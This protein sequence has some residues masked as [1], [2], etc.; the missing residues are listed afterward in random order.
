MMRVHSQE[1]GSHPQRDSTTQR[2]GW[3]EGE[4][5]VTKLH[6]EKGLDEL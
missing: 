5:E 2:W 3:G 1:D 6:R 4:A